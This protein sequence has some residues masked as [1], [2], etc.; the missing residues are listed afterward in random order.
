MRS[1]SAGITITQAELNRGLRRAAVV[2][3]LSRR[4][5]SGGPRVGLRRLTP[6][7]LAGSVG[8]MAVFPVPRYLA[9][10]ARRDHGVA[11]WIPELPA[12]V[13]DLAGRGARG[14]GAP[15]PPGGQGARAAHV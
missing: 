8:A 2:S 13:A 15:C 11:E 1:L 12:L 5:R 3:R 6:P 14:A 10:T 9:E 4:V 7:A